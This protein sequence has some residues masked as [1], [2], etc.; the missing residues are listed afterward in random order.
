VIV[1]ISTQ[2]LGD[3]VNRVRGDWLRGGTGVI[4]AAATL[5]VSVA[6]KNQSRICLEFLSKKFKKAITDERGD[7]GNSKIGSGKNICDCP[8]HT[9]LL[10]YA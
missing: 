6:A 9:L 2:V 1:I 7:H 10:P 5:A 8:S 3:V 4:I